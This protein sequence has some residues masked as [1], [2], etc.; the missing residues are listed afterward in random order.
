MRKILFM[1]IVLATI[2]VA[3]CQEKM[4]GE[5]AEKTPT[6][7]TNFEECIAAGN[8]AMESYPRQ[9]K[10]GEKTFTEIIKHTCTSEEKQA[11]IC[12]MD[13]TPVCGDNEKTYG[14][15]CGA[16]SSGEIEYYVPGECKTPDTEIKPLTL[17]EAEEIALN[18]EC[19]QKG[20]L[21]ENSF[22]NENSKTW[23]IDLEMKEEFKKDF[24]NPACVISEKTKEA[25]I[26]WRCT[27]ALPPE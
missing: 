14:N 25:E 21:T 4:I 12:T 23:W 2:F 13:Y 11:M 22:Y 1:L 8:P 24:C 26:N 6:E 18:T 5:T 27:G 17:R 3:G 7:I 16:C 9:C 10:A 15:G 20:T 19:T